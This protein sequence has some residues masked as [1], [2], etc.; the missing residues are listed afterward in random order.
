MIDFAVERVQQEQYAN[1][2]PSIDQQASVERWLDTLCGGVYAVRAEFGPELAG[3]LVSLA[4]TTAVSILAKC[5]KRRRACEMAATAE[6]ILQKISTGE[7][8]SQQPFFPRACPPTDRARLRP[9]HPDS[10]AGGPL[11]YGKPADGTGLCSVEWYSAAGKR[12]GGQR[13]AIRL[14]L[15]WTCMDGMYLRIPELYRPVYTDD[16]QLWRSGRSGLR[17]RTTWLPLK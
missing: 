15:V 8:E 2:T 17:R 6:T 14:A 10:G 4:W 1:F 9:G 13:P 3:K 7:I 5:C 16:G 12:A 11:R